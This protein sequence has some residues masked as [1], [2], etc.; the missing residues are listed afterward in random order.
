MNGEVGF[1]L[2]RKVCLSLS[3][4]QETGNSLTLLCGFLMYQVSHKSGKEYD[5]YW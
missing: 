2:L 4:F 5:N 3:G 1:N